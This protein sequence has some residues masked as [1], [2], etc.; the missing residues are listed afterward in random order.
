MS[1]IECTRQLKLLVPYV[2]VLMLTMFGDL[3][4]I[5][6]ALRAGASGYLLKRTSPA[7]LKAAMEEVRFGGAPMSP[8]VARQIVEHFRQPQTGN[9]A[10]DPAEKIES[11]SPGNP[12][13]SNSLRKA[14]PTRKSPIHSRFRSIPCGP[15][16][17]ASTASFTST[18][19]WMRP[20]NTWNSRKSRDRRSWMPKSRVPL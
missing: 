6:D 14:R 15:I 20:R 4:R 10:E 1:G 3:D 5:F 13:S 7:A 12:K 19:A 2:E 11:L 18:A 17:A 16:F 8:Y 9:L